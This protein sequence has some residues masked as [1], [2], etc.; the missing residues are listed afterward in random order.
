MKIQL[1][2]T[3]LFLFIFQLYGQVLPDKGDEQGL[4]IG[5]LDLHQDSMAVQQ[6]LS[7][8][9]ADS[10]KTLE[11]RMD[12]YSDAKFG[13]FI[14]WGVYSTAGGEWNGKV[15]HGYAEHLMRSQKIPL[16]E[17]KKKLVEPFNPVDFN[18]EEW[19]RQ[20]KDA[21]MRYMII[22]AKHHD[23]FALFV[24]DAYPYDIRM[25]RFKHDPMKDLREAARKYGLKFGFYYSHAFDWE[26]PDAPGNDWD[27]DNPGGDKLLFGT[28]WWLACPEF[29]PRAERYVS[30]KS[31]PQIQELIR[32][33]QP[34]ILWFDTPQ[35]LPLYENVRILKTI[36]DL[37]PDLIVVNGRLVRFTGHNFG[38]YVNT[39]DRAAYFFP[40]KSKY[41]EAIPTTN[42][43]YGYSR[44]DRSHKPPSHFI[45]LLA[46]A[47]AK[48]G[49]LLMNVGPM[50]NGKWDEVDV[51]IFRAVGQWLKENGEA[52]YAN[53]P[54]G[55]PIQNWGV[56][57]RK[58]NSMYLHVF[59]WPKNGE[60]IV[61]GLTADINRAYM[62][63]NQVP[64][65]Y[66][67][68][69]DEDLLLKLPAHCPD[70]LNAVVVLQLHSPNFTVG[71]DRLLIP[72][73]ENIL[74]TF[75]AKLS[76]GLSVG[77]G[78]KYRN[79]IQNWTKA[80]Q[81]M[82]W[83]VRLLKPA[84]FRISVAFNKVDPSDFG[85]IITEIDGKPYTSTYKSGSRTEDMEVIFVA[86]VNFSTGKHVI[87][88]KGDRYQGKQFMR[89][90]HLILE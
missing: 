37:S 18:A 84:T 88:L 73:E 78:K 55:L 7:G 83:N 68:I 50:G 4:E 20:A 25:T 85:T 24:S 80:T 53:Q 76:T 42:E 75:D 13:C 36:R 33:Y 87:V 10:Q 38:D 79:Y 61:G 56:T 22:T 74:L 51:K 60:L 2:F 72:N 77:D 30:E 49:N 29:L 34:D 1:S 70:T 59:Q 11:K 44:N 19:V 12:W 52:I 17:Y 16:A 86:N 28:N 64:V 62:L 23:G 63:K 21:G 32:N 6:A 58:G 54:T 66:R 46:S 40:V 45:R 26:H 81:T 8:W 9:W 31:I 48:G 67:K 71:N 35:K 3:I 82:T 47:T 69:S 5:K 27:Y 89:P 65:K 43:S 39:G 57:T 14:H 90:M 15:V 41:W